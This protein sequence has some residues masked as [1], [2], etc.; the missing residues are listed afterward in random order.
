MVTVTIIVTLMVTVTIT[1]MV[2]SSCKVNGSVQ[3]WTKAFVCCVSPYT[4]ILV[5]IKRKWEK[6]GKI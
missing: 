5:V 4:L 1:V 2:K 6:I 3:W